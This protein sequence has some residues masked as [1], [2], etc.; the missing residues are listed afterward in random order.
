MKTQTIDVE[1]LPEGWKAKE[2]RVDPDQYNKYVGDD[3]FL[4]WEAKIK[5]EKIQPRRI[6]LEE[7]NEERRICFGEWYESQEGKLMRWPYGGKTD[8]KHRL[9]REVKE[10]D[11]P[12][13]EPKLSLTKKNMLE[14]IEHI[15]LGGQL[16]PKIAEFID[17]EQPEPKLSLSA[18]ECKGLFE[19]NQ[20]AIN[21]VKEFVKENS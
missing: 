2:V 16:N 10:P 4:Y 21:K 9:W 13:D 15:K 3:G 8:G 7:T 19:G 18:C 17:Y 5:M 1:G 14:L 6:V 20:P 12:K 11:I